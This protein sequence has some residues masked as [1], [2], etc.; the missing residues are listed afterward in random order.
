MAR[1]VP[2]AVPELVLALP[3]AQPGPFGHLIHNLWLRLAQFSLFPCQ[4]LCLPANAVGVHHQ[5]TAHRPGGVQRREQSTSLRKITTESYHFS[6]W[7]SNTCLL[8]HTVNNTAVLISSH[9]PKASFCGHCA[10]QVC[11]PPLSCGYNVLLEYRHVGDNRAQSFPET[12]Q[13]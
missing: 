7:L 12:S 10:C 1:A 9:K 6:F 5:W 8:H 3:D 13:P 4:T 11:P 2:S